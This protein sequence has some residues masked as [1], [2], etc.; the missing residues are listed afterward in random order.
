[1]A[2]ECFNRPG[3]EL[4][5]KGEGALAIGI[6]FERNRRGRSGFG[7]C[8]F[9]FLDGGDGGFPKDWISAK[10]SCAFHS[11]FGRDRN[12]Q[13][14]RA[15]NLAHPQHGRIV[16]LYPSDKFSIGLGI[17]LRVRWRQRGQGKN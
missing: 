11:S 14:H 4:Q 10:H 16:G 9:P 3:L 7:G 17:L 13:P 12:L 15:A 8:V 6:E 2:H 1:V 5:I